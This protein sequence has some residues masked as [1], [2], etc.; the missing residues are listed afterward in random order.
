M[1]SCLV[2]VDRGRSFLQMKKWLAKLIGRSDAPAPTSPGS[3][4][5]YQRGEVIGGFYEIYGLLGKG[6]FGLVLLVYDRQ[7]KEVCAL[8]T[9]RDEF[10]AA[11]DSK[12]NFRREA[13][14]WV[15]LGDHPFVLAARL[16]LEFRSEE[17]RVG[18]EWRSGWGRC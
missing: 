11:T 15:D 7:S 1:E 8:K 2:A 3:H 4:A 12:E 9:F 18:K 5:R 17:R 14:N 16:V 10:L 13:S 6:G